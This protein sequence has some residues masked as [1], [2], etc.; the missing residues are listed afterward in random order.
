MLLNVRKIESAIQAAKAS[1]KDYKHFDGR[2]LFLLTKGTGSALWRLRYRMKGRDTMIS[3]GQYPDVSLKMARDRRDD[4]RRKIAD[5]IDPVQERRVERI[6]QINT[7]ELLAKEYLK[8][9]TDLTEGTI[10]R[11]KQRLNKY[12]Y[13]FIGSKPINEISAQELLIVLRKVE[14]TGKLDTAK[15]IR[16]LCSSIWC[17]AGSSVAHRGST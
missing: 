3:L 16:E 6:A 4:E 14:A 15:R 9:L 7:F 11:H 2:G 1:G 12:V 10:R 8:R 5:G 17:Y 13:P